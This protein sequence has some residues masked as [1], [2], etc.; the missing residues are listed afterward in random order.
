M[1]HVQSINCA[2][3]PPVVS[4]ILIVTF[5]PIPTEEIAARLMVTPEYSFNPIYNKGAIPEKI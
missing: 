1:H 4:K 2:N 5:E 3:V